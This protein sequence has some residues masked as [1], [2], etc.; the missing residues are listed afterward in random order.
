MLIDLFHKFD[1]F[2]SYIVLLLR[3]FN[4]IVT[5][6]WRCCNHI[7][8]IV[9]LILLLAVASY[10]VISLPKYDFGDMRRN[11]SDVVGFFFSVIFIML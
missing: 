3:I 11:I 4:E 5:A 1:I 8:I 9:D 10:V 2:V 7:H 6:L